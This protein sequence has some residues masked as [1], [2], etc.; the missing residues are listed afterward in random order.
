MPQYTGGAPR[1]GSF[2]VYL[3]VEQ[4]RTREIRIG[5]R[6]R[7]PGAGSILRVPE[8]LPARGWSLTPKG[9]AQYNYNHVSKKRADTENINPKT[10]IRRNARAHR[11]VMKRL[12]GRE[13]QEDEYVHHQDFNKLN[14]CP[15][16]LLLISNALNPTPTRKC[17]LTG[18]YMN[19]ET[20]V[21]TYGE[22]PRYIAGEVS[23]PDDVPF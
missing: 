17:P 21:R 11:E 18:R 23:Y 13:L 20:Y 10:Q 1:C 9:Y 6:S 4:V 8:W 2:Q 5:K 16:N 7:R 12:L 15:C 19:V 22:L 3:T 14:C